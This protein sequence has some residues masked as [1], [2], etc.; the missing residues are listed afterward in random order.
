MVDA[1]ELVDQSI[2]VVQAMANAAGVKLHSD[3]QPVAVFA[4][5]DR[6][7]QTLVNLFGNAIMFT[8]RVSPA[9][10]RPSWK[11]RSSC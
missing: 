7:I 9:A 3:V 5:A 6:T 1:A 8:S 2:Q 4:D 10:I 11:R